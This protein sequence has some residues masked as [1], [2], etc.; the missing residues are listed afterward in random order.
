[1]NDIANKCPKC[2]TG[3]F[4]DSICGIWYVVCLVC[5]WK[6]KISEEKFVHLTGRR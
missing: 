5:N 2:N 1:M 3:T 4:L 6:E